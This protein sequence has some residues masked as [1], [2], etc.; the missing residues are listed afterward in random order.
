VAVGVMFIFGVAIISKLF[1]KPTVNKA[2]SV[3]WAQ[4]N[5]Y[6]AKDPSYFDANGNP[7]R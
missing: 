4:R 1:D 5:Q 6:Q 3:E 2:E 7:L